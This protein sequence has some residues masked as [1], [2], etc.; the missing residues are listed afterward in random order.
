M[1][2][3][4]CLFV[5]LFISLL[6]YLIFKFYSYVRFNTILFSQSALLLAQITTIHILQRL[7]LIVDKNVENMIMNTTPHTFLG[8]IV[9]TAYFG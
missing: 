7:N 6:D 5:Y 8:W 3:F 2:L 9:L 4:I 1:N